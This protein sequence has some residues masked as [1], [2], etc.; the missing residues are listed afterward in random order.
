MNRPNVLVVEDDV[1][2]AR[3]MATM[4]ES[5]D[6][7]VAIAGTAREAL[8]RTAE[9]GCDVAV[10]DVVLPDGDGIGLLAQL[11]QRSPDAEVVFVTGH[12]TLDGAAAVV[13]SRAV[14]YVVKPFT[15]Q[16]LR[17]SV[18][19]ALARKSAI[20]AQLREERAAAITSLARGLGH[21]L[22]NPL[23]GAML[24]LAVARRQ[25]RSAEVVPGASGVCKSVLSNLDVAEEELRRLARIVTDLEACLT[26]IEPAVAAIP[27]DEILRIA[28]DDV[29][30]AARA[31]GVQ[32]IL[33]TAQGL[34]RLR[35]D[36]DAVRRALHRITQ[37]AV[38]AM[39]GGGTLT[40]RGRLG[41][42]GVELEI[43]DTG[44]GVA[45]DRVIFDP[46]FTTKPNGTGLGLTVARRIISD[47]RGSIRVTSRPGFAR[48]TLEL[49][50]DVTGDEL[51]DALL[52]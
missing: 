22:R 34:P 44:P 48:F 45:D 33:Q 14:D 51:E 12:A 9:H 21:E 4:I 25:V 26:P 7:R 29:A 50:V 1:A 30:G 32:V 13:R 52:A 28:R 38:E 15:P 49:P 2:L 23:N 41:A 39:P 20:D 6:V 24:K 5:L 18:A 3:N 31:A 40:L 35:I 10:L 46:F 47:Q 36:A 19:A 37:N 16:R 8:E 11:K 43:E 17:D 27:V 42:S